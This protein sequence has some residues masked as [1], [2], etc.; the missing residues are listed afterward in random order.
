MTRTL[1]RRVPIAAI[2][3][4]HHVKEEEANKPVARVLGENGPEPDAAELVVARGVRRG[5]CSA[6]GFRLA[7]P[8]A[9]VLFLADYRRAGVRLAGGGTDHDGDLRSAVRPGTALLDVSGGK[10]LSLFSP[11]ASCSV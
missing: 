3:G 6:P 10:L 2:H 7:L 5:M 1:S 9:A 11:R 8:T 4:E